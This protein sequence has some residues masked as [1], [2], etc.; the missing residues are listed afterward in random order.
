MLILVDE[1]DALDDPCAGQIA[2]RDAAI[3]RLGKMKGQ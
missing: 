1:K 2:V 3:V